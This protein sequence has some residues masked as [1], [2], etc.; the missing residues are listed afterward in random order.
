MLRTLN[1]DFVGK[2]HSGI[3]DCF[4]IAQ[5]V[6]IMIKYG[7][8]FENPTIIPDEYD[9]SKD[10][11]FFTFPSYAPPNSWKCHVCSQQYAGE[12]WNKPIVTFCRFCS[13][14]KP[15]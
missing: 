12:I 2:H 1:L 3:D 13:T 8:K 9:S 14:P 4:S 7:F 15:E 10:L 5:I 6:S 11:Y